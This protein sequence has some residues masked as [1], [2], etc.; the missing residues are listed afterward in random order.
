MIN[1]CCITPL[2]EILGLLSCT[3]DCELVTPLTAPHCKREQQVQ[4]DGPLTPILITKY[5]FCQ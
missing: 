4:L 2:S 3:Q 5:Q 1:V